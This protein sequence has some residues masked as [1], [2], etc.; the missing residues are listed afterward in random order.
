ML[1]YFVSGIVFRNNVRVSLKRPM[2]LILEERDELGVKVVAIDP[3]GN[4]SGQDIFINDVLLA[5]NKNRCDKLPFEQVMDMISNQCTK[6][7]ELILERSGFEIRFPN[8]VGITAQSGDGF[9]E[10]ATKCRW[11][12][13]YSCDSGYCGTCEHPLRSAHNG[14]ERYAR[15]CIARVP[16]TAARLEVLPPSIGRNPTN[17]NQNNS[18]SGPRFV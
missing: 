4:S 10:L 11:P 15:L 8:G 1:Q 12:V 16:R 5:V 6:N 18:P 13:Q 2:G 17:M 9:S 14:D 3:E 7:I